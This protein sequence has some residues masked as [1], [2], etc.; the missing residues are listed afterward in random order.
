MMIEII[1]PAGALGP[2]EHDTELDAMLREIAVAFGEEDEWA[3]KYGTD[4]RGK[5]FSMFRYWW[6]ECVC[7]A[8]ERNE[9]WWDS[10]E[11]A[12]GCFI[13][14]ARAFSAMWGDAWLFRDPRHEAYETAKERF[15]VE[16]GVSGCGWRTRCSCGLD[17]EHD[18]WLQTNDHDPDCPIVRPNF[19]WHGDDEVPELEV[20]WYKFI[21]RDTEMSREVMP[22]ELAHIRAACLAEGE[23]SDG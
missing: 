23:G 22:E 12:D 9:A 4:Y 16:H 18:E 6:G 8:H 13:W 20:R 2:S 3:E 14:K 1:M 19:Y 11:H 10:H 15:L 17:D 5:S 21:S 7:G